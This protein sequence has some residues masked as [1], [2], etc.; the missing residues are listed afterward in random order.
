MLTERSFW[1]R[2][3]KRPNE[4]W[5]WTGRKNTRGYGQVYVGG[6]RAN[7]KREVAHRIAW[8]FTF[9]PIPDGLLV[10]HHCDNPPCV[11]PEHLFLGTM[12]D[13]IRDASAKGRLG[14]QRYPERYK[15]SIKKATLA[16]LER[17]K[18]NNWTSPGRTGQPH[19][20]ETKERISRAM[21]LVAAKKRVKL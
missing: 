16:S 18:G 3:Q 12:S 7:E 19:S 8:R 6:G 17:R 1:D 5:P 20:E 21:E 13:N 4:C 15:D 2:V 11:N 10:C 14:V 9:G